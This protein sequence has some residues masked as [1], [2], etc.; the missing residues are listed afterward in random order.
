ML[1]YNAREIHHML[2]KCLQRDKSAGKVYQSGH[3]ISASVVSF[4]TETLLA[5]KTC[6]IPN[7]SSYVLS[8]CFLYMLTC[9][10]S[11]SREP[12]GFF[13]ARTTLAM[14]KKFRTCHCSH[15]KTSSGT[16]NRVQCLKKSEHQIWHPFHRL[17]LHS[18]HIL[19][20][21]ILFQRA[22]NLLH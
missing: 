16:H 4:F 13:S 17:L 6:S 22:N 12:T 21:L 10:R 1:V 9:K 20:N 3:L 5:T 8:A 11:A 2:H 15:Q 18:H 14:N 19:H 7:I